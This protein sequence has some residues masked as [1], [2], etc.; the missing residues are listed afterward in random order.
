MDT[1]SVNTECN[2]KIVCI[3]AQYHHILKISWREIHIWVDKSPNFD[4]SNRKIQI[5]KIK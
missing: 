4:K 3:F 2:T 5:I 1:P